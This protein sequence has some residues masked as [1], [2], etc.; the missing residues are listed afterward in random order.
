M[1]CEFLI[2]ADTERSKIPES[3]AA[4]TKTRMSRNASTGEWREE[5]YFPVGTILEHP[6]AWRF[7]EYGMA[8]P[9]D[10]EC[11]ARCKPM[12]PEDRAKLELGYK[13]DSLGIHD[14]EDRKLFFDGV[15]AGYE[16][17]GDGKIAYLPGP[18]WEA[19]KAKQESLKANTES[20][21]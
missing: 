1:K 13:A 19:W 12:T 6:D 2:D 16:G 15:I 17:L 4:K 7:V 20:E 5:A 18:N 14:P 10:E 8:K 11:E 21:I 3:E 9:A